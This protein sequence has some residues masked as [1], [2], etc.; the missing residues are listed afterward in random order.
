MVS[1]HAA[2]PR[3]GRG[4]RALPA[5][6]RAVGPAGRAHAAPPRRAG[7]RRARARADRPAASRVRQARRALQQLVRAA[8]PFFIL[9]HINTYYTTSNLF[10]YSIYS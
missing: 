1:Q 2:V 9:L 4:E 3:G 7:R 5:H 10:F 8:L 6:L